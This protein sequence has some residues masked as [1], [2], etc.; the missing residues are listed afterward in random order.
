MANL[1]SMDDEDIDGAIMAV[2]MVA[3]LLG[4]AMLAGGELLA[5]GPLIVGILGFVYLKTDIDRIDR[6]LG[7]GDDT[8]TN[9][10]EEALT[11]LRRRYARGKIDQ[12]EFERR[13]NDLLETETLERAEEHHN[14]T[15]I[16]E[17][18]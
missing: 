16:A 14:E 5:L 2:A 3:A 17:R 13:L 7:T 4:V 12:A 9:P 15:P 11:V 10:Q 18:F 8:T 1:S 6:W